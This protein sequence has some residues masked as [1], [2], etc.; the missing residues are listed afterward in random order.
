MRPMTLIPRHLAQR[1][2]KTDFDIYLYLHFIN[3]EYS[4]IFAEYE[5]PHLPPHL[6][7]SG[8]NF[9]NDWVIDFTSY[10]LI[11]N[12]REVREVFSAWCIFGEMRLCGGTFYF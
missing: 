4:N 7:K 12:S 5:S 8:G 6:Y 2:L 9:K 3:N 10:S 11:L 1:L